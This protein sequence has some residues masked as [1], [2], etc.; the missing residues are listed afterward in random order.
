M[1][2]RGSVFTFKAEIGAQQDSNDRWQMLT[3][4]IRRK[5]RERSEGIRLESSKQTQSTRDPSPK[6]EY[7]L[8]TTRVSSRSS[9]G[10][11]GKNGVRQLHGG[12]SRSSKFAKSEPE[13]GCGRLDHVF[14]HLVLSWWN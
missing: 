6:E 5:A 2:G 13:E 12:K 8:K 11:D 9:L 1:G 7:R 4:V 10:K 3:A 14:E